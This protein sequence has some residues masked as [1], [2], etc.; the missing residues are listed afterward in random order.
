MNIRSRNKISTSFSQSSMTDLV[1]LLLIFFIIIS[2]LISPYA[3]PV[4][5]PQGKNKTKK[6]AKV[7]VT[8]QADET[9]YVNE[10]AVPKEELE[11]VLKNELK[12]KGKQA[13][14]LHVDKAVPSGTTVNVLNLAKQNEWEIVL[15]T[16]PN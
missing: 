14:V 6:N 13:I 1:F 5:L 10:K 9:H 11:K 12:G 4:E 3:L 15:A 8:I 2:T 7:S 16:R